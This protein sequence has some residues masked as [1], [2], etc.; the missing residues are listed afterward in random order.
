MSTGPSW[1]DLSG[2]L[3]APIFLADSDPAILAFSIFLK[4]KQ[5]KTT[6][7]EGVE[8]LERSYIAN[9]NVKGTA[10]GENSRVVPQEVKQNYHRVQQFHSGYIPKRIESRDSKHVCKSM[11]IAAL[12]ARAKRQK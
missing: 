4:I 12:I 2:L 6:N 5:Q 11:F 1:L 7:V 9:R 3:P 10:A 8:K